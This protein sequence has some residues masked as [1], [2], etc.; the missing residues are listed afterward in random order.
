MNGR[1]LER[2][3][4]QTPAGP[5]VR[6][7]GEAGDQ[8]ASVVGPV[9]LVARRGGWGRPAGGLGGKNHTAAGRRTG[10][11]RPVGRVRRTEPVLNQTSRC[12]RG[13]RPPTIA[14]G[15]G[16]PVLGRTSWSIGPRQNGPAVVTSSRRKRTAYGEPGGATSWSVPGGDDERP[17]LTR[18]PVRLGAA[19]GW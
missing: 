14:V 12:T 19:Q 17:G 2:G 1:G 13:R 3:R 8:L 7:G 18:V 16:R 10:R 9:D 5:G 15:K 4:S 11:E 6:E